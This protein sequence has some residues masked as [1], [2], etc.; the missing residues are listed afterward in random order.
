M[1]KSRVS[2]AAALS[3]LLAF[4][5][6]L[7][8]P[9]LQAQ[10]GGRFTTRTVAIIQRDDLNR[11]LSYPS[12]L[13]YDRGAG[14]LYVTS[15]GRVVVYSSD[16]FPVSSLGKGRGITG[17]NSVYVDKKGDVYICQGPS[18]KNPKARISVYNAAFL[19]VKEIYFEGFEKARSF[20]PRRMAIG[21]DGKMYV[22][23]IDFRGLVVLD[24]KGRFLNLLAPK[25]FIV[26]PNMAR[27][28]AINDVTIDKK[29]RIYLLSEEM[30][31]IY[32]YDKNERFL[33]KFGTKGG[34]TGKLSR[35]RGIA[36]DDKRDR[37]Y[38]IDYMRHTANVY[39]LD[40]K[41][42]GEF[43]GRGWG[44]GWFNYPSDI[45][46]DDQGNVI[47]ADTFNQRVQVLKVEETGPPQEAPN[48]AP[49][50]P[51]VPNK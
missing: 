7:P 50:F 41:F 12:S 37:I 48:Y 3:L 28:A 11:K 14:E 36:V 30:G 5:L 32:V 1:S 49:G 39:S 10:E 31:R 2:K 22:A 27:V 15:S 43:G 45:A 16:Y 40:G 25:D 46:V 42:L 24:E 20:T 18:T 4:L 38:V 51:A 33:F 44:P 47:V 35:P 19:P 6:G 8:F 29:G 9:S 34:S 13:F 26:S 23:G 21:E 17:A